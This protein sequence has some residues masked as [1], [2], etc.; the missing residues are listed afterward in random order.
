MMKRKFLVAINVEETDVKFITFQD[1]FTSGMQTAVNKQFD[2]LVDYTNTVKGIETFLS[3]TTEAYDLVITYD[4]LQGISIGKGTI[5]KWRKEHPATR[6]FL[7]FPDEKRGRGKM[8]FFYNMGFFDVVFYSDFKIPF[9]LELLHRNRTAEE[10]CQYY[11]IEPIEPSKKAETT[12]LQEVSGD[13]RKTRQTNIDGTALASDAM[14]QNHFLS[15]ENS[16]GEQEHISF[17]DTDDDLGKLLDGIYDD[18]EDEIYEESDNQDDEQNASV[19]FANQTDVEAYT[20]MIFRDI[21]KTDPATYNS[22]NNHMRSD[23]E[24]EEY[25][26]KKIEI[27]QIP[28]ECVSEVYNSLW[29]FFLG[30]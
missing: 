28:D 15:K 18:K 30:V 10:A 6:F 17:V 7:L 11:G 2:I 29:S 23:Q 13:Y 27:F 25:I 16:G 8:S 22:W 4:N 3:N 19:T 20:E 12:T 26:K 1:F 9:I 5:K 21:T 24:M 14:Q